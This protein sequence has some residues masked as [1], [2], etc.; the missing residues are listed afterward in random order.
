MRSGFFGSV[1]VQIL[2]E[3]N[4]EEEELVD[5]A[6]HWGE[7][8]ISYVMIAWCSI[9]NMLLMSFMLSVVFFMLNASD[10]VAQCL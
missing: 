2:I 6:P 8:H 10:M 9:V 5:V 3:D 7:P 4:K 1:H